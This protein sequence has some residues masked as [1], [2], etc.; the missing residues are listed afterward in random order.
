MRAR[1]AVEAASRPRPRRGNTLICLHQ[2]A[3]L[4][5]FAPRIRFPHLH[6]G[7]GG[8]RS[9]AISDKI[10]ANICRDTDDVSLRS[11]SRVVSRK[12][13]KT[14]EKS[15]GQ[16]FVPDAE[17][18]VA[19]PENLGSY[20][21]V[22]PGF[23]YVGPDRPEGHKPEQPKFTKVRSGR[24]EGFPWD[25]IWIEICRHVHYEGLPPTVAELTRYVQEWCENQYGKQPGDST[26][27]PK[28]G[29]LYQVL[30]RD[31]H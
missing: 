14:V 18:Y 26:L 21:M 5:P 28:L 16:N 17:G 27:R 4:L 12:W 13:A 6:A 29:K 20:I 30:R 8:A 25:D 24:P 11:W 9:R 19:V 31:E 15:E 3:P 7:A 2:G 22:I 10:S 1:L 23:T